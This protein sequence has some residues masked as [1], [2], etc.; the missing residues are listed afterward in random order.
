MFLTRPRGLALIGLLTVLDGAWGAI[1]P[2]VGPLFGYRSHGQSAWQ[3]S[4]LHG[5][6]YLAPGV[7]AVLFGLIILARARAVTRGP[8][9]FAGLV[10]AACGAWF[11]VGPALW[12]TFGTGPVFTPAATAMDNFVHQVGYNLGVGVILAMLGGMALKALAR[13][14]EVAVEGR[15]PID[16][17]APHEGVVGR[18][19]YVGDRHPVEPAPRETMS[20]G[21]EP[22][23]GR[24]PGPVAGREPVVGGD[25]A[26]GRDRGPV[27]GREPGFGRDRGPGATPTGV[28]N[29]AHLEPEGERARG[30]G[31]DG[32]PAA[33]VP[34]EGVPVDGGRRRGLLRRFSR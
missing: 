21:S 23:S 2:F 31:G 22:V 28:G 3:W 13:D 34:G 29:G 33:G 27:A 9:G 18:E 11:V 25:R 20:P 14:R 10:V 19:P 32:I 15:E 7:V 12:P 17:V 26:L 30:Q 4:S 1:V 24:D 5:V 16:A 8:V 6:L